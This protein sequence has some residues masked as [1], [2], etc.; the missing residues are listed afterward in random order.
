MG[1]NRDTYILM[2]I[3]A[4][5]V[6]LNKLLAESCR[7][8]QKRMTGIDYGIWRFRIPIL[9]IGSLLTVL[10]LIDIYIGL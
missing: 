3:G 8:A 4:L 9:L 5:M 7:E 10:G 6:L 1:G 2:T